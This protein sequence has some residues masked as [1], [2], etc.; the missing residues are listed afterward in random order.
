METINYNYKYKYIIHIS[1][2]HIRLNYRHDEYREVFNNLYKNIDE[3]GLN[4][5]ETLIVFTGDLLHDKTTLTSEAI[6]LCTELLTNLASRFKTI[7]MAGNHDGYL[8]TSEKIDMIT[9]VLHGKN[10]KDLYYIKKNK[11]IQFKN[12][13]FGVNSVFEEN[14]IPATEL[15]EYILVNELAISK[16]TS[17]SNP[18]KIALY[19]GM[20][21][22][23]KL[24]N[25]YESKGGLSVEDFKG[26]DYVLL[27]D[28]HRHQYLNEEKTI[29]YASS[30]ISQNFSE[31]DQYHGYI[32]WDLENKV[33]TF[34]VIK[35][36][37]AYKKSSL[38]N[39]VLTVDDKT[40]NIMTEIE[41]LKTYLPKKG[42]VQVILE[43]GQDDIENVRYLRNKLKDVYWV[44]IN[45]ILTKYKE[46]KKENKNI[47]Y[48]N[49]KDIIK[50]VLKTRHK[51]DINQDMIDWIDNE[52]NNNDTKIK[53]EGE[54]FELLKINFSNL[55][56]YGE[57]NEIDLTKFN[58]H[59]VVL[60]CG[61]NSYGKSSLID[62]IVFNLY[63][64]YAREVSS[65]IK[66]GASGIINNNKTE[67]YS[68]IL[69]KINTTMY[70]IKREY[71]KNKKG[72][73]DTDSYLYKLIEKDNYDI[74]AEINKKHKNNKVDIY[75]YKNEEYRKKLITTDTGVNKEIINMLGSRDNFI[76][77]NLMLQHDNITFKNKNQSERKA[78]L[79]K[80]LDLEKY[81][82]MR[83]DIDDERKK[84]S[85]EY[86]LLNNELLSIDYIC[87]I[88]QN[89]LDIEN[90]ELSKKRYT[91]V[92]SR[93]EYLS[94]N[95]NMLNKEY[96]RLDSIEE[97][98]TEE[99]LI[100]QMDIMRKNIIENEKIINR[101]EEENLLIND[102]NLEELISQ[103]KNVFTY[104]NMTQA[105]K[106][107]ITIEL[108]DINMKISEKTSILFQY[109]VIKTEF[110]NIENEN[111]KCLKELN[112]K[113][114]IF[115]YEKNSISINEPLL[116]NENN[117]ISLHKM[118]DNINLTIMDTILLNKKENL[119]NIIDKITILEEEIN[120][121]EKD[122][123]ENKYLDNEKIREKLKQMNHQLEINDK[124]YNDLKNHEYNPSCEKCMK[125]PKVVQLLQLEDTISKIR[126]TIDIYLS[127][128]DK[129]ID[130]K[131]NK[132]NNV[133]I[134]LNDNY[135]NMNK[136]NM[137]IRDIEQKILSNKKIVEDINKKIRIIE[138][139]NLIIKTENEINSVNNPLKNKKENL[140]NILLNITELENRCTQL[141]NMYDILLKNEDI[142]NHNK[143]LDNKINN[144]KK[145]HRNIG[146]IKKLKDFVII[147]N[148]KIKILTNN[149]LIK[150]VLEKDIKE[151]KELNEE[152]KI[153]CVNIVKL[154]NKLE[155][156]KCTI[157]KY[158]KN[159][160]YL[161]ILEINKIKYEYYRDVLD[162]D[163]ISLYIVR[164]YLK[165]ITDGINEIIGG[166]INK[167]V[168]IYEEN[169]KIMIDI[170]D[171]ENKV[172]T[173]GGMETFILDIAFKIVLSRISE[174]SEGNLIIIDEGISALDKEHISNIEELF[175]FLNKYYEKIFLMSHIEEIK[176]KVNSKIYIKKNDEYSQICN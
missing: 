108:T 60:I 87:L 71:K 33:S 111:N 158:E 133:K 150:N 110:D 134:E 130:N 76:L 167:R 115:K 169:E 44:E 12:I 93:I 151:H 56:V 19:H 38:C 64:D 35:N 75:F 125:N 26:Y 34:E 135:K 77:M 88:D 124:M 165:T 162:K 137:E 31:N 175:V 129:D 138:L 147:S 67:G 128:I 149:M 1:D 54:K 122:D 100:S 112:E 105:T 98:L 43:N 172:V 164:H 48:I 36:E 89:V 20:I 156:N 29:A 152:Y 168:E 161:K 41:Q 17:I 65:Q 84:N 131:K 53:K 136:L 118:L 63:N 22:T 117:I 18:I 69:I 104:E 132:Y 173:L 120:S 114:S 109:N 58:S 159:K 5:E 154:E 155:I 139:D 119:N 80:L 46:D 99:Q 6:I 25:L 24:Q 141:N 127:K 59:D 66:K 37:H 68:E 30:L 61:K 148:E 83:N 11:I 171:N 47:I 82:K 144:I 3:K 79:Y 123:I 153:L 176:D 121:Y 163:G 28:I 97:T 62:I 101:L 116:Q 106:E 32:L 8:N 91:T 140:E 51:K 49:R 70:I 85:R 42:R 72:L 52:L 95:I 145:K 142:I 15:D 74:V 103:K 27:G 160:T 50:T 78:I 39:Q 9:G 170:W 4:Y 92:E 126:I 157:E 57:N 10:I 21:G 40:F 13:I 14:I 45:N 113:M 7:I 86:E 16:S 23:V 102:D 55:F 174:I 143:T 146:D 90:L 2:I 166:I 107:E 96:I 94:E 73:V 81:E